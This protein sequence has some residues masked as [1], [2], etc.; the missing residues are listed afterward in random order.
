MTIHDFDCVRWLAAS[1]PVEISAM[2]ACLVDPMFAE[3]GDVDTSIVSVR[4]EN[5]A[6]A[7]IDNSRRSG[8]GYDVRTEIFGSEG[9]SSSASTGTRRVTAL[10]GPACRPTTS[11]SSSSGS[12]RPMSTRSATSST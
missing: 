10:T 9:R 11:I 12:T 8:F 2:A 3:L 6:L 1:E 7:V 5:G 4:F